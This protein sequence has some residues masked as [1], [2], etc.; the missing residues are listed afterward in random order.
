[1][2]EVLIARSGDNFLIIFNKIYDEKHT[3]SYLER[4]LSKLGPE[5]GDLIFKF[6]QKKE[7][8]YFDYIYDI[9]R[10]MGDDFIEPFIIQIIYYS[11]LPLNASS[12]FNVLHFESLLLINYINPIHF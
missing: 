11:F 4:F 10:E 8:F 6:T 7:W 1:M 9:M 12:N 3:P 5:G 2:P